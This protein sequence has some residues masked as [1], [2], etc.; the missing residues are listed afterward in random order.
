MSGSSISQHHFYSSVGGGLRVRFVTDD[1][2]NAFSGFQMS[3]YRFAANSRRHRPCPPPFYNATAGWQSLPTMDRTFHRNAT[4]VFQINSTEA[5]QLRINS[6][7]F[8]HKLWVYEAENFHP[9]GP[10]RSPTGGALE[11]LLGEI[12]SPVGAL[13]SSTPSPSQKPYHMVTSRG[14][15]FLLIIGYFTGL[16]LAS[17]NAQPSYDMEFTL[18]QSCEWVEGFSNL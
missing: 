6:L 14:S 15:S 13:I 5:V 16:K 4:C 10:S 9:G 8:P 12:Q 17:G 3:F 11:I 2:V 18:A 1:S 7:F